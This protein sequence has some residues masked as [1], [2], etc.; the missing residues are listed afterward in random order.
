MLKNDNCCKNMYFDKQK[1][2]Q[3]RMDKNGE[4]RFQS[5]WK[6]MLACTSEYPAKKKKKNEIKKKHV[7]YHRNENNW[8][9]MWKEKKSYER[10]KQ[11]PSALSQ[12]VVVDA[13][14][15]HE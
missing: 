10:N 9:E 12:L 8:A 5:A 4:L 6:W 7:C 13:K 3:S 15:A 11:D 1:P 14:W 2:I